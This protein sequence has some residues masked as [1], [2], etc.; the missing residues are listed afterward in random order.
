MDLSK[1]LTLFSQ[2]V[3]SVVVNKI[4][5]DLTEALADK[6]H[7]LESCKARTL[8]VDQETCDA[9][10]FSLEEIKRR[11]RLIDEA[12]SPY[13]AA[14]Q[15][16]KRTVEDIRKSIVGSIDLVKRDLLSA[17]MA[18]RAG[19]KTWYDAEKKRLDEEARKKAEEDRKKDEEERLARA[20][21]APKALQNAILDMGIPK[22]NLIVTSVRP[23]TGAVR[24]AEVWK[25]RASA[26][27]LDTEFTT[28]DD[29]GFTVPDHKKIKAAV[30]LLK[31][32][33]V[34][35]GV[36]TYQESIARV[37]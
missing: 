5:V 25:Y 32:K 3:P 24:M 13:L 31:E 19:V 18:I 1:E 12:F 30:T 6:D 27:P 7:F 17:D 10:A 2:E 33:C 34:I 20:V 37:Y 9:A 4:D 22:E 29:L 23:S 21:A 16:A 35:A 15:G 14:A 26:D 36:A 11:T 8:V 28:K